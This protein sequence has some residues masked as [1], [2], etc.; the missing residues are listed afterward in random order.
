MACALGDT[1]SQAWAL[2]AFIVQQSVPSSPIPSSLLMCNVLVIMSLI[3]RGFWLRPS[4]AVS[5]PELP[6]NHFSVLIAALSPVN[7]A[8]GL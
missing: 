5:I 6:I 4:P 2:D 1:Q 8:E 3:G 7:L